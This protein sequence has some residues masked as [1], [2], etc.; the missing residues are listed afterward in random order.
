MGATYI[1]GVGLRFSPMP[2]A[3]LRYAQRHVEKQTG[4]KLTPAQT[5]SLWAEIGR[6][7][8]LPE[9]GVV[10]FDVCIAIV[11]ALCNRLIGQDWPLNGTDGN[12]EEGTFFHSFTSAAIAAG[13]EVSLRKA[14]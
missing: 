6:R 10:R 11:D 9:V 12:E 8:I 5:E 7:S 4:L 1:Q 2:T 13:Y 14:A 3:D